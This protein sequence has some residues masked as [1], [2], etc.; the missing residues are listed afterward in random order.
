MKE[1][2]KKLM[3]FI[4]L[5]AI[6]L[7][8]LFLFVRSG[9]KLFG[10]SMCDSPDGIFAYSVEVN[11]DKVN[12]VGG[13]SD[14]IS[15]FVGYIYNIEDNNLYIGVNHNIFLGFFN[16]LGNFNITI[17]TEGKKID[18]V[19]FKNSQGEKLIWSRDNQ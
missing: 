16:R 1:I 2:L 14:S 10:F 15:S 19:Y 8:V 9:W 3:V 18:N 4:V 6:L 7:G 12:I 13:I 11:D 5:A 17:D